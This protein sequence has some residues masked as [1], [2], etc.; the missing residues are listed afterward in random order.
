MV[1]RHARFH[2]WRVDCIGASG[3]DAHSCPRPMQA[4]HPQHS[5]NRTSTAKQHLQAEQPHPPT[6]PQ[7]RAALYSGW[8]SHRG[9]GEPRFTAAEPWVELRPP[10]PS[11]AHPAESVSELQTAPA[12][13]LCTP[14]WAATSLEGAVL[15]AGPR[16]LG[17]MRCSACRG[18]KA[19]EMPAGW[20][21][22]HAG[23]AELG[24]SW[25]A[26]GLTA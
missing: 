15:S 21:H 8:A 22:T 7:L 2:W 17:V 12:S 20:P 26:A 18:A 4:G 25:L 10:L 1:H 14:S 3:F 24:P 6:E 11:H 16:A 19:S 9:A 5:S 13:R 23:E